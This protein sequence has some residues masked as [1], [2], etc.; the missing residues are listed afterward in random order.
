MAAKPS[1]CSRGEKFETPVGI[2]LSEELSLG[3]PGA[4]QLLLSAVGGQPKIVRLGRGMKT[5]G[6]NRLLA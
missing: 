2:I 4:V 5:N 1:L 6:Q 3:F